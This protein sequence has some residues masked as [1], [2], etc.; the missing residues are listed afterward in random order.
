MIASF[1]HSPAFS[2]FLSG[3]A[4][5]CESADVPNNFRAFSGIIKLAVNPLSHSPGYATAKGRADGA[6]RERG[7]F[8]GRP[9][10]EALR[11]A[12]PLTP[13]QRHSRCI[14]EAEEKDVCDCHQL[15]ALRLSDNRTRDRVENY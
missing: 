13:L 4:R 10:F 11:A 14:V 7:E 12:A 2:F 5:F 6:T 15:L 3:L 8:V 9:D 1:A